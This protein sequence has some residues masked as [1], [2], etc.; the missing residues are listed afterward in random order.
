MKR[1]KSLK[2]PNRSKA[3]DEIKQKKKE[4]KLHEAKWSKLNRKIRN[5]YQKLHRCM[6]KQCVLRDLNELKNNKIKFDALI[7]DS[8]SVKRSKIASLE[9]S[10][11]SDACIGKAGLSLAFYSGIYHGEVVEFHDSVN[12]NRHL[13]VKNRC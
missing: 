11:V 4:Q 5:F 6:I 1:N 2:Q 7:V 9:R 12:T 3:S 13:G 10:H 8:S